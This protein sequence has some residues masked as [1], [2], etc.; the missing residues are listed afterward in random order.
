MKFQDNISMPTPP[1]QH[2][3][4]QR[5]VYIPRVRVQTKKDYVPPILHTSSSQNPRFFYASCVRS[6]PFLA[7]ARFT[8]RKKNHA[9][10]KIYV[11]YSMKIILFMLVFNPYHAT[12]ESF[13]TLFLLF[14]HN[15]CYFLANSTQ[16]SHETCKILL[17]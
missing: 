17:K 3:H 7:H 10:Q 15:L 5:D 4:S 9:Q 14:T 12:V 8:F 16:K 1:P 2:T 6:E 11:G 13:H